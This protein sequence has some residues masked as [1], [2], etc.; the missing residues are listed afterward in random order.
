MPDIRRYVSEILLISPSMWENPP[1]QYVGVYVVAE[2]QGIS[3]VLKA[4]SKPD[5]AEQDEGTEGT[6]VAET[7]PWEGQMLV[8]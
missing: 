6:M 4:E 7:D 3:K 5:L 1:S 2:T 8:D